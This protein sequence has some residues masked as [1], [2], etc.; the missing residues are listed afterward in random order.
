[1]AESG[2]A[3]EEAEEQEM[4]GTEAVQ[5]EPEKAEP[6]GPRPTFSISIPGPQNTPSLSCVHGVCVCVCVQALRGWWCGPAMG[7]SFSST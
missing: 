1:M 7:G 5:Q 3:A 2:T 4:G 6:K